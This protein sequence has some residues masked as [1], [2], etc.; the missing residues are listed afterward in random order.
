MTDSGPA[1]RWHFDNRQRQIQF[2]DACVREFVALLARDLADG[3]EF[4]VV[5]DSDEAVRQ[6]N[7]RFRKITET[8]DVLSFPDGE[9]GYLGDILI[10]A[11]RADQQAA[12]YG[13]SIERE[14]QTLALH[15]M[16]HLNGYDHET[17]E[18]QMR[19]VEEALRI[20]YGLPTGLIARVDK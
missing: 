14:I 2:D 9:H 7:G 11:A 10:S 5:V 16:L 4:S 1:D 19:R 18:G 12:E 17:D 3:R 15:G 8:T 6:A 13:H 20:D